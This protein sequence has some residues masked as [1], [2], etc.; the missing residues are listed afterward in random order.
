MTISEAM[1]ICFKNNTKVYPVVKGFFLNVQVSLNG[2][3]KTF[4]TK[5]TTKN[6][7][8]ALIK[9]YLFYAEKFKY[10]SRV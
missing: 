1:S 3:I 5:L 4:D 8:E 9:T 2:K 10:N 7:N 6:V